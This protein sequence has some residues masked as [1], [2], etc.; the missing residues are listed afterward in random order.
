MSCIPRLLELK[1]DK[2]IF[3]PDD[4]R[5]GVEDGGNYKGYDYLVTFNRIGFR[6]GYVA[7]DATHPLY[8]KDLMGSD[9]YDL[10][11]H[12]GVTFFDKNHFVEELFDH[13]CDDKWIGFDCGHCYDSYDKD[14]AEKHFD[15]RD[16]ER[17]HMQRMESISR[18]D[19]EC[20]IRTKEYVEEQCKNL[21][22]QLIEIKEAA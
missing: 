4:S 1:G 18:I 9:G 17:E 3:I 6:C 12:G 8:E 10:S 5:I 2:P 19:P 21:I 16:T 15:L 11:V 20:T 14:F 22:D 13:V 7:I